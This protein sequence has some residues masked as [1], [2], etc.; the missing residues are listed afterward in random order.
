MLS[1]HRWG[2]DNEII[3]LPL[4]VID[5]SGLQLCIQL[6]LAVLTVLQQSGMSIYWGWILIGDGEDGGAGATIILEAT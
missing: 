5:Y 2:D 3:L 4:I 1:V 6:T